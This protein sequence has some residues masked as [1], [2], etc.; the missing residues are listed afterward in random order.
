MHIFMLSVS[1]AHLWYVGVVCCSVGLIAAT[2]LPGLAVTWCGFQSWYASVSHP[3]SRL[4]DN[5]RA[6]CK[7]QYLITQNTNNA[8]F[9]CLPHLSAMHVTHVHMYLQ[10]MLLS[11]GQCLQ[12]SNL[13]LRTTP[14]KGNCTLKAKNYKK[15]KTNVTRWWCSFNLL[16]LFVVIHLSVFHQ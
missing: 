7:C 3:H 8:Q 9:W 13:L 2:I 16:L 5:V 1:V 14:W 11:S 4:A 12:A 15:L 10:Y 6:F